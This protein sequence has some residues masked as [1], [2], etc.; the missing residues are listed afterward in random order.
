MDLK[1]LYHYTRIDTAKKII[2]GSVLKL[3]VYPKI[4][5]PFDMAKDII[6]NP[7]E[8]GD[9]LYAAICADAELHKIRPE[10]G[11]LLTQPKEEV[12]PKLLSI[13][14]KNIAEWDF[15]DTIANTPFLCFSSASN[16]PLMWG[17][18]GDGCKGVAL[19][20]GGELIENAEEVQYEEFEILPS[21]IN[22]ERFISAILKADRAELYKFGVDLL[23]KKHQVWSYEKEYRL[24][25]SPDQNHFKPDENGHR[26][27]KF[28]IRDL[29][30]IYFGFGVSESDITDFIHEL[31]KLKISYVKRYRMVREPGYFF[32]YPPRNY[33]I[34]IGVLL[35]SHASD[36]FGGR[37]KIR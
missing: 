15:K 36:F 21:V 18:Y 19:E 12:I 30:G 37:L 6:Y 3:S 4:N 17:H 10:Y 16:I 1:S 14:K 27:F 9:A 7:L 26:Y 29:K 22:A 34:L 31:E 2:S 20:F 25:L 23:I 11:H 8:N 35:S 24:I 5:D 32:C 28:N 33:I 13:V